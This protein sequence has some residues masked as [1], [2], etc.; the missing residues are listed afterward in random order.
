MGSVNR[1]LL[2]KAE[3]HD[4]SFIY[5]PLNPF[6]SLTSKYTQRWAQCNGGIAM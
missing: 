4:Y 1:A 6:C 5:P 2:S 3:M